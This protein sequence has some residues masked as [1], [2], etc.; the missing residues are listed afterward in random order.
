MLIMEKSDDIGTFA[1]MGAD[2][3]TIK[4][5]FVYE[6]WS[7]SLLGLVA[8]LAVGVCLA[9]LQQ[10]FGLL[11]MPGN[12]IVTAYPAVLE[13]RDV[14]ISA[15]GVGLVGYIVALLPVRSYFKRMNVL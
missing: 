3:R 4:R 7:I 6:G 2:R 1:A 15:A 5:I 12:Y 13:L 9:L 14:L 10:H 11:K 8:G